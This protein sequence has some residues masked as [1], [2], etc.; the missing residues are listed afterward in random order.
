M[1]KLIYIVDDEPDILELISIHLQK[2]NFK[3]RTFLNATDF[4]RSMTESI[5][6]DLIVLDL[7]LPDGDGLE[8]CKTLRMSKTFSSVPVIMVTAK[9]DES[10]KILGLELGADD[11]VTK[12]F[13]PKELV[14]RIK[15][16]LRRS[17]TEDKVTD[18]LYY[19]DIIVVDLQKY[20]VHV[21]GEK[22]ELTLTELK[23]LSLLLERQGWVFSRDQILKHLWGNEKYVIDRTID[24]H[25]SHLRDKL[26]PVG[27][28][29]KNV[30]GLGYKLLP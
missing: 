13:S 24:V 5:T 3:V 1:K 12:P 26:G 29:I 17:T 10:D 25:I 20:E 6:P 11:Y 14:A 27:K 15:A 19:K 16:N 4:E 22:V 18:K 2:S 8:L 30:R 9:G 21:S 28:K 23:I 7:M